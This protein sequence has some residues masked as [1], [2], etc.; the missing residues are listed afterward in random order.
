MT[1]YYHLYATGLIASTDTLYTGDTEQFIDFCRLHEWIENEDILVCNID[2]LQR[3]LKLAVALDLV[4]KP[5]K[6]AVES[7]PPD[8]GIT[9]AE[10]EAIIAPY[11]DMVK[12]KSR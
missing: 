11:L 6:E 2:T 9:A 10:I 8:D 1:T 3:A 12:R 5:T 7:C 4:P